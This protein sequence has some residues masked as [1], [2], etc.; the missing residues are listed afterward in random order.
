MSSCLGKSKE[1]G[2]TRNLFKE[3]KLHSPCIH[4]Q[5]E[6]SDSDDSVEG[7]SDDDSMRDICIIKSE[8]KTSSVENS[9]VVTTWYKVGTNLKQIFC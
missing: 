9:S 2:L 7:Y 8:W 1:N 4:Q 3:K 5:C 6:N